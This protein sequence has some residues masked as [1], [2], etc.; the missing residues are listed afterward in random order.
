MLRIATRLFIALL[1]LLLVAI[2]ALDLWGYLT[3]GKLSPA[4]DAQRDAGANHGVMVFGAT[5][6]V[7]D[8]LL[9][10]AL[11]DPAV[12]TLYIVT[13]RN[14]PRIDQAVASGRARMILQEDFTDY[15]NLA[16]FLGEVNTV[17]WG[18]GTSSLNVDDATYTRIHVDFPMA[19]LRQWLAARTAAPMAFHFVT[20]MGTDPQSD[21]HWAREK[22]RTEREMAALAEGTGLRT[23][24]Y[25]SA[26]ISPT[27]EQSNPGHDLL[28]ALLR[29]GR[30][31]IPARDLGAA[32]LEISARTGELPNGT[33]IDN[34]DSI[35]YA[36]AYRERQRTD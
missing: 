18:L 3:L 12:E 36:R 5:G 13:R 14:S 16:P 24:S 33:L 17:L 20:G 1:I 7:G 25:R 31:V 35:A 29:P 8:G 11:E 28:A 19:F 22:G 23:F 30:L 27:S 34:A 32:M 10:A 15:R 2:A 4:P 9:K 21:T 26:F 6:S